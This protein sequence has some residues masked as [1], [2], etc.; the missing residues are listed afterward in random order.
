MKVLLDTHILLYW[1]GKDSRLS[2]KQGR[3]IQQASPEH[4]LLIANISLWEIANLYSLGRIALNLPLRE[5]LEAATAPPLVQRMGLSPAIAAWVAGLPSTFHRDPA[6]R[7]IVATA[8]ILGATLL[9]HDSRIID[10]KL[11]PVLI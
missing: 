7:I 1:F 2:K 9:T 11:V 3:T 4:P 6:D 5:W 8:Q 10:A